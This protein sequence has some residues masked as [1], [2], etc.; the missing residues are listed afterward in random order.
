MR[1]REMRTMSLR[2]N[3]SRRMVRNAGLEGTEWSEEKMAGLGRCG[4]G[5]RGHA[6]HCASANLREG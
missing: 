5:V 4:P 1:V 6:L 2:R 3:Q